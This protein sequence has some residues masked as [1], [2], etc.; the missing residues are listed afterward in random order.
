MDLPGAR[1]EVFTHPSFQT[2]G[3]AL[4]DIGSVIGLVALVVAALVPGPDTV[5]VPELATRIG[6]VA[7]RVDA[8][9]LASNAAAAVT[10]EPGATWDEVWKSGLNVVLDRVGLEAGDS[11][12]AFFTTGV[13]NP[14]VESVTPHVLSAFSPHAFSCPDVT[15]AEPDVLHDALGLSGVPHIGP[16]TVPVEPAFLPGS[17]VLHLIGDGLTYSPAVVTFQHVKFDLEPVG[18]VSHILSDLTTSQGTGT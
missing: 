11:P 3:L 9:A 4:E 16:P 7:V 8:A 1:V 10:D 18:N 6:Y 15:P 13:G 2:L 12:R 14:I 5:A 17:S